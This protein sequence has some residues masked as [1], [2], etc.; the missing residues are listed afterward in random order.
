MF[1]RRQTFGVLTAAGALLGS[2][3][4][5]AQPKTYYVMNSRST[6]S[7]TIFLLTSMY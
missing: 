7:I 1:T 6:T 3:P 4:S 5:Q 2:A